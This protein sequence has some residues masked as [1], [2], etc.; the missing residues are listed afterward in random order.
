MIIELLKNRTS[1]RRFQARPIP[2][3]VLD[4]ILEAGRLSP[5]GGN[6]QPWVFEVITESDLIAQIARIAHQQRWIGQAPL[7]IVL[8]T[9]PVDD[10]RGGR[11][12][13]IRRYPQYAQS[14][15][16]TRCA[17]L[18]GAKPGGTPDQDCRHAHGPGSAGA[19]GR[20]LLGLA[21]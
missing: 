9:L 8:C 13:Q 15:A 3:A 20:F 6:E 16:A 12:I 4:D 21:F 11:D 19:W 2:Q 5:S 7:L 14:I 1:V 17:A 18:L 10:A